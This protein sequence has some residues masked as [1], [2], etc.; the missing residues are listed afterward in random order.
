MTT[1]PISIKGTDGK[2]GGCA[3]K[4]AELTSGDLP[5]VANQQLFGTQSLNPANRRIRD[6]SVRWCD[7]ERG[8]P[9]TYVA[10]ASVFGARLSMPCSELARTIQELQTE[11][12]L[13]FPRRMV[14]S[15]GIPS[16]THA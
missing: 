6:R 2:S 16:E 12:N 1:K 11:E 10:G 8:R 4:V 3:Q 13:A 7:R 15:E 9:L 14:E 5:F